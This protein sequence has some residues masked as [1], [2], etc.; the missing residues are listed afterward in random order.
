[1]KIYYL[2]YKI[3][4]NLN[5]KYYIGVHKTTNKNDDYM[6][7]GKAI[8]AA[9]Q[10]Y[11]I[12]NFT[13]I[14]LFECSSK[15]E[16]FQKE[17]ELVTED[18]VR[19]RMSYNLKLGGTANFYYINHNGL[20]HKNDQHKILSQKL[21]ND[22][23]YAK[24]F[25]EKIKFANEKS[26]SKRVA[27]LTGRKWIHNPITHENKFASKETYEQLLLDGWKFGFDTTNSNNFG[28]GPC[29]K[30]WIKNP[31]TFESKLIKKTDPIPNG[32]EKGKIQKTN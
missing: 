8:L 29:G 25:S 18:V 13:K 1:M 9:E 6:G 14:I 19:D 28:K 27:A 11:G 26:H 10:K 32:W 31:I 15:E 23:V 5:G 16:M 20:N 3:V 4:N 2:V 24:N 17:K 12:E 7:S 22:P 21:K 30:M